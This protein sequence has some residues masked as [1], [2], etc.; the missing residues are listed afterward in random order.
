MSDFLMTERLLLR[1]MVRS[2]ELDVVAWRNSPHI[3]SMSIETNHSLLTLEQHREWFSKSRSSRIDYII[4]IRE[5]KRA[6]GSVS[7]TWRNLSDC[8][9][10]G[11]LGKYI[12]DLEQI[13]KGYAS[14]ATDRWLR[15]AFEDVGLSCVVSRTR[16]TNLA[17]IKI[18]ERFGFEKCQWPNEIGDQLDGWLFMRLDKANW[19][20]KM[21]KRNL[22]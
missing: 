16:A 8:R 20:A 5:E 22:A 2:D 18:N 19:H 12:G 1:P 13:G 9:R 11:E 15:Y 10:C 14:E 7:F 21:N 4:E 3:A 6:I 17:N